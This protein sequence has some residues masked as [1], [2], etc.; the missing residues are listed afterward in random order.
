MNLRFRGYDLDIGRPALPNIKFWI[1]LEYSWPTY[2]DP[3]RG[4]QY[5]WRVVYRWQYHKLPITYQHVHNRWR[6][7][8]VV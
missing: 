2:F 3:R 7:Q 1:S 6:W 8:R 4:Q 5:G